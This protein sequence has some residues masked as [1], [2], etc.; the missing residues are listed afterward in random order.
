[1]LYTKAIINHNYYKAYIKDLSINPQ[2]MTATYILFTNN[3]VHKF[4]IQ[5]QSLIDI[6]LIEL[7][8]PLKSTMTIKQ[9]KAMNN[10]NKVSSHFFIIYPIN[11]ISFLQMDLLLYFGKIEWFDKLYD[12]IDISPCSICTYINFYTSPKYY[13]LVKYFDHYSGCK[14][15]R[16]NR[17]NINSNDFITICKQFKQRLYNYFKSI[18]IVKLYS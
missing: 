15:F 2:K 3:K 16:L 9:W 1:M 5:M 14:L 13:A 8:N 17:I 12:L 10:T 7:M 6:D 4:I 18:K 11:K